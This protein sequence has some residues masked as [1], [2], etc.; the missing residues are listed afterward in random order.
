MRNPIPSAW[1][2]PLRLIG[3]SLLPFMSSASRLISIGNQDAAQDPNVA[4]FDGSWEILV[5]HILCGSLFLLLAAVQFSPELWASYRAWHRTAG[6]VAMVAGVIAGASGMWLILAYP[7]GELA[8]LTLDI[9]RVGFAAAL[10][11]SI[12]AAVAAI[13]RSDVVR[14]RAWMI[15]AFALA[16]SGS[17]QAL[18]IGIWLGAI[19]PLTPQ[20]ATSLITIGFA[21][22]IAFA[23]WWIH[24]LSTSPRIFNPQRKTS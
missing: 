20:S 14:H 6:K 17:T 16:V 2:I 18:V 22:N 5:V 19:G 7:R 23:E 11:V 3:L 12:I 10:V 1:R 4:R 9:V 15:R 8:T 21:I 24:A 13:R